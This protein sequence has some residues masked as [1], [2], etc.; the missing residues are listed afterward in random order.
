MKTTIWAVLVKE[1]DGWIDRLFYCADKAE[2]DKQVNRLKQEEVGE[3]TCLYIQSI[4]VEQVDLDGEV[5][6][7]KNA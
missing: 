4:E 1:K 3:S 5:V 7:G 2:L 6:V